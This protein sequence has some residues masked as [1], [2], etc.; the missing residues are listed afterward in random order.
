MTAGNVPSVN[1]VGD[2]IDGTFRTG[3]RFP[4]GSSGTDVTR[5]ETHRP[6]FAN[7]DGLFQLLT[8]K[9]V[10]VT[11]EPPSGP[12]LLTQLLVGFG[13]TLLLVGPVRLVVPRAAAPGGGIG[14]LGRRR[15]AKLY[16]PEKGRGRRSPTSPASTRSRTRSRR[17]STSCSDPER[18][19]RLGAQIPRGVLLSGPPGTGKTLLARAVAGEADVPFFSHVGRRSSS[20]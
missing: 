2:A 14:G 8:S 20:R 15:R 19:R 11:A 17:S 16:E 4:S 9:G 18:Y 1:A 12:S 10:Q 3:V 13:P 7:D 5:F 6:T